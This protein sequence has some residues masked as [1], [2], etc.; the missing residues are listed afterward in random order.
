MINLVGIVKQGGEVWASSRIK[1]HKLIETY[2]LAGMFSVSFWRDS[3]PVGQGLLIPEVSTYT[4]W[5]TTV[6]RTPLYEL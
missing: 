1:F 5:R 2:D 4:Q 6:G 3:P